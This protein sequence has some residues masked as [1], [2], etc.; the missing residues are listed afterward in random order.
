M[1][2]AARAGSHRAGPAGPAVSDARAAGAAGVAHAASFAGRVALVTGG[3]SGIGLATA[4]RLRD[5]GAR[6]VVA[7]RDAARGRAALAALGEGG[8]DGGRVAFVAADVAAP[9]A[10]AALVDATVARFG[11]LDV[12]VNNAASAD[13]TPAR[14]AD[15][16]PEEFEAIV[17]TNLTAAWRVLRA[18][19]G[20]MLAAP[21]REG[22]GGRGAIVNV[23]SV[24]A[25][26]GTPGAASYAASKAALANLTQSV[27]LEYAR[28]AVRV[29]C[30]CPGFTRTPM[31][32][33]VVRRAAGVGLAEAEA[34]VA[35]RVPMGRIGEPAEVAAAIAWL[36]SDAASYV[37]GQ[38]LCVDGGYTAGPPMPARAT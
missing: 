36:C 29:N 24:N 16:A 8:G 38:L 28:D 35:A 1:R 30:V 11:R 2:R 26:G 17:A 33:G 14:T 7:G 20:A 6:V 3:T 19:V 25:L 13:V 15:V 21:A 27:A 31:L 23:A 37:T 22:A 10:A 12:L 18:A 5:G 32:D 34:T 4:A 9:G